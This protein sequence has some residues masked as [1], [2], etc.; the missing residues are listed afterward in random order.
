VVVMRSAMARM[1]RFSKNPAS[2]LSCSQL[3]GDKNMA[4]FAA[5]LDTGLHSG[6]WPGALYAKE[7]KSPSH[8]AR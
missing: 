6:G 2:A 4:E 1:S 3:L 5:A 7:L 8:N